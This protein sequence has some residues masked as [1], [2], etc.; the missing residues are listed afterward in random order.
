MGGVAQRRVVL[1]KRITILGLMSIALAA[2]VTVGTA[3]SS[4]RSYDIGDQVTAERIGVIDGSTQLIVFERPTVVLLWATWSESSLHAFSEIVKASPQ[5]GVR[6]QVLPIN[7]DAPQ[8]SADD[9]ARVHV[10]AKAA[11]WNGTIYHDRGYQIMDSWGTLSVPTVVFTALGGWIEEIEHHWSPGL[12]DKLFALYFGSITDSFPGIATPIAS[13]KC[14]AD[15][16]AARRLWRLNRPTDAIALMKRVSD[17]CIGVSSDIARLANWRW[18]SVDSMKSRDPI[19]TSLRRQQPS[20]WSQCAEAAI[21]LRAGSRDS[22]LALT[23]R[24]I[25]L[26]SMYFPAWI[27]LGHVA[28]QMDD[29]ATA[30]T[31]LRWMESLNRHHPATLEFGSRLSER[32]GNL[33][34]ATTL[35]QQ[36]VLGRLRLAYRR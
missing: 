11:G 24:A 28:W 15:A 14:L 21:Y 7:V 19:L 10:A 29:L 9:S 34:E 1:I 32:S 30:R 22:A 27:V 31:A 3:Y 6:W 33:A 12:R 20:A 17:S 2:T 35:M 13:G 4:T 36:A 8:L 25:A 18:Q 26:D 5:G 23:Q 16:S